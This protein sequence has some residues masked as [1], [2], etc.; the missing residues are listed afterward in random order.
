MNEIKLVFENS[1]RRISGNPLGR[2]IYREQVGDKINTRD[3]NVIVFPDYVERVG[4]SFVQGFFAE[5]VA[6]QG[7]EKTL[8]IIQVQSQSNKLTMDIYEKLN[9]NG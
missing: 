5:L 4:E 8:D 6:E 3:K 9:R 7:L 1:P 2:R